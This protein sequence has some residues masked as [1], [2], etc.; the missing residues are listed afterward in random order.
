MCGEREMDGLVE[1]VRGVRIGLV[2]NLNKPQAPQVGA[3]LTDRL[4]R[5]GVD[6]VLPPELARVVGWHGDVATLA[7]MAPD[8]AFVIVL[9]GDGTL[10]GVARAVLPAA[11]PLL[12]V[13][14]GH[15]G[16]LT[17]I[18]LA[19]LNRDLP[20]FLEGRGVIDQR[21]ML[22]GEVLAADGTQRQLVALND[23]VLAKGPFARLLRLRVRVGRAVLA[24]YRGDGVILATAT[25]ST[26]YSLS[27]GGPVLHPS[28]PGVI[29]TP[30]CPHT[31]D[32][33]PTVVSASER[34]SVEVEAEHKDIMLTADGQE[35]WAFAPG[36]RLEVGLGQGVARLLRR[37]GWSF[38]EVL[39]HKIAEGDTTDGE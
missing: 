12:G 22:G 32:Q 19:D 5:A 11:P 21:A 34:V 3:D 9:G 1:G 10:L 38:Y 4:A 18:E 36:D 31:L 17:E 26:A 25:G 39:R 8:V 35:G 15:V 27:A 20:V 30:I 28:V 2:A 14:L 37:P 13:N 29:V 24:S 16:F 33:R 7:D 23:V 6:V